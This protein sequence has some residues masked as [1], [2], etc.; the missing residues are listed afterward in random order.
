MNK[1]SKLFKKIGDTYIEITKEQL[2]IELQESNKSLEKEIERL[3][4]AIS[5]AIEYIE[6]NSTNTYLLKSFDIDIL[7]N[8]LKGEDNV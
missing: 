8:I 6:D 5:K 3:N 4:N 7:L 1:E 2:I